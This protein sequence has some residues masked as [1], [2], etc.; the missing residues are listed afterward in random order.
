MSKK[1][2]KKEWINFLIRIA[3]LIIVIVIY[4]YKFYVYDGESYYSKKEDSIIIHKSWESYNLLEK[5]DKFYH[6]GKICF[7]GLESSDFEKLANIDYNIDSIYVTN[8]NFEDLSFMKK[9]KG[10]G[11]LHMVGGDVTIVEPVSTPVKTWSFYES[12]VKGL[13][14]L[15]STTDLSELNFNETNVE[16]AIKDHILYDSSVF[17][18]FDTVKVLSLERCKIEDISGVLEMEALKKIEVDDENITDEQIDK[19]EEKG[20][21]VK[22]NY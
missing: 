15:S 18:E 13:N 6:L 19:L 3:L 21:I 11:Y 22:L 8:T 1:Q 7:D 2:E 4:L 10:I 20:I 14:Y 17:A 9:F 12:N 5:V 16:G